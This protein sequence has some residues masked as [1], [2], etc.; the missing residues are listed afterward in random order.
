MEEGIWQLL[1]IGVAGDEEKARE[2]DKLLY[3]YEQRAV[4]KMEKG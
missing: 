1:W 3:E 4:A 2:L